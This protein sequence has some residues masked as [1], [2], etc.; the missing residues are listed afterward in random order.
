MFL[1]HYYANRA[2]RK[3]SSVVYFVAEIKRH[4]E[5][6]A[7]E[8]GRQDPGAEPVSEDWQRADIAAGVRET[9]VMIIL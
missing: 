4:W 8:G 1:K 3:T 9:Q 7:A 2:F 5:V 6:K